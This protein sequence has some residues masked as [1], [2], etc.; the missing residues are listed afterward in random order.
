[1]VPY[2]SK[3]K[4]HHDAIYWFDLKIAQDKGLIFRETLPNAIIFNDSAP[5][6]CLVK[7]VGKDNEILNH[8]MTLE[9]QV[10]PEVT[11]KPSFASASS[12]RSSERTDLTASTT[13]GM[14][15]N[16]VQRA[17]TSARGDPFL[18]VCD[19]VQASPRLKVNFRP[20]R[21]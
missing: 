11:L 1:M 19:S 14:V 3:W 20:R 21:H 4:R 16:F 13:D 5:P 10:V 12:H 17:E 2:K 9:L 18:F 6:D 7:V 15:R 8:Q